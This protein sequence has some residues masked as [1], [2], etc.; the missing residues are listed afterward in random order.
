MLWENWSATYKRI[1]LD[2]YLTPHTNINSKWTEYLIIIPGTIRLLEE[3]IGVKFFD[4]L[5]LTPKK[6][7]ATK[8]K[9]KT[10]SN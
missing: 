10:A 7:I 9:I 3:N 8:A 2:S 6:A 1:K 4:F 5:D